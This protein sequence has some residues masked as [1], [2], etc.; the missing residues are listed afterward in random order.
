[1]MNIDI[2]IDE[3][4]DKNEVLL[5][6]LYCSEHAR[7]SLQTQLTEILTSGSIHTNTDA[8]ANTNDS[9]PAHKQNSRRVLND[10]NIDDSTDCVSHNVNLYHRLEDAHNRLAHTNIKCRALQSAIKELWEREKYSKLESKMLE[11]EIKRLNI[12]LVHKT[13]ESNSYVCASCDS[14][15]ITKHTPGRA[16]PA[17]TTTTAIIVSTANPDTNNPSSTECVIQQLTEQFA[18]QAEELH[19]ERTH[20]QQLQAQL[21]V[22]TVTHT[23]SER[24]LAQRLKDCELKLLRAQSARNHWEQKAQST[25]KDLKH[26]LSLMIP[27]QTKYERALRTIEE[28][29]M[30]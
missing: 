16:L 3:L 24:L 19:S 30:H 9:T 13:N 22:Q 12:E 17:R 5:R 15:C 10:D 23:E 8:S 29:S 1:M 20:R 28:A 2:D 11:I 26:R 27:L 7:L 14:D 6:D 21:A 4:L 18:M 25:A